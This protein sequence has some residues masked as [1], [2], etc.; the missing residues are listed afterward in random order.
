MDCNDRGEWF[1]Q[2]RWCGAG[3]ACL[4]ALVLLG[5]MGCEHRISLDEF[6]KMEAELGRAPT[7]QPSAKRAVKKIDIDKYLGPF[8]IGPSDVLGVTVIG[9]GGE[10]EIGTVRARVHRDGKI[11]LPLVGG[12]KVA[13]MELED[14]EQ[15]IKKKYEAD[16]YQKATVHVD[17]LTPHTF[18]VLVTGAVAAPGLVPVR[19]NERNLLFAIVGAGGAS[20]MASGRVTLR[21]LRD[22]EKKV[23]LDLRDP[24]AVTTAL[25]LP[26][27][28]DGDMVG[29]E[30]AKPNTVFVGGLVNVPSPQSYPPGVRVTVLQAIAGAAGLRTDV[31]P[32]EGTLIRRMPNGRDVHVKLDLNRLA[33]GK[34]PNIL[35]AAGDILWV[36]HTLETYAQEWISR[37]IYLRGGVN[38]GLR[39]NFIH[40]KD[41]YTGRDDG[42]GTSLLIGG[43][44]GG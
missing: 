39:Y 29:V 5:M 23:T 2:S 17:V 43:E 1:P 35:L 34:D 13:D 27:L 40:S 36:P 21:R 33:N 16:V 15:A 44:G 41:I 25:A 9:S 7:T 10:A 22:P 18:D 8:Q 6:L 37:N 38:A 26:P 12:I 31:L 28:E 32:R 3:K 24:E 19:R 20:D 30:A 14:A 42:T 11:E 4:G